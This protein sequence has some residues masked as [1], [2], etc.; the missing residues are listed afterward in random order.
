MK[1]VDPKTPED[2]S[3]VLQL[4][5]QAEWRQAAET[6]RLP[7]W[8]FALRRSYN[9][10]SACL[11]EIAM[12]EGDPFKGNSGSN[13]PKIPTPLIPISANNPLYSFKFPLKQGEKLSDYGLTDIVDRNGVT[14]LPVS[15]WMR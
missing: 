3:P 4:A 15:V 9:K 14:I 2:Q 7:Y 6:W 10:N 5:D 11:P 8:D 1:L 12:F 13:D